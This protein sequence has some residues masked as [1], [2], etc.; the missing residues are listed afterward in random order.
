MRREYAEA[1]FREFAVLRHATRF[2]AKNMRTVAAEGV[3]SYAHLPTLPLMPRVCG[4][5]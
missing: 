3:T 5:R 1:I 2:A 4:F